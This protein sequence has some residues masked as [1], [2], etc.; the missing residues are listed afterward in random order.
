MRKLKMSSKT[1]LTFGEGC[2]EYIDYC[3]ARNLRNG[4]IK[5]YKE[6]INSIYRFISPT[7]PI[8]ELNKTTM[9]N[10]IIN[11]KNSLHVKDTT[12]YTYA[13]DLKTIMRYFMK[14]NYIS[15]FNIQLIKANKEPIDCYSDKELSL[16]LKKPNMKSCSFCEY[17]SWVII[18]FL[19]STGVRMNSLINIKIK[20]LDFD[21]EVVYIKTTKN[22]KPLIIPL[23]QTMIRILKEYLPIRQYANNEEYLFCNVFGN[24]LIKT[25]I[26]HSLYEYNKNRGVNTTGIHRY[27]H[28]FAKKWIIKGGNVVTLQKILGHSS[29]QI[30]QNYLN[31]LTCDIGNDINK[32]SIIDDFNKKSIHINK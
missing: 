29:L 22:R 28:T 19:L 17:K 27:R 10:F 15:H 32:Y 1:N 24:Q 20:D 3:I 2:E 18:N 8:E 4:T 7:T 25:T 23:N 14:Q 26:Y 11:M 16:L 6:S 13:R 9:D 31:I 21:N 5:H 12:L 30:T